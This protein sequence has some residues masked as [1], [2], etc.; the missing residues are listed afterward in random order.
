MLRKR[1]FSSDPNWIVDLHPMG[2]DMTNVSISCNDPWSL[3]GA[4]VLKFVSEAEI[5]LSILSTFSSAVGLEC[6]RRG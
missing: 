1:K 6:H 4:K 3:P 5:V 2:P